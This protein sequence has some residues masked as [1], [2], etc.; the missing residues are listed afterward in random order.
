V[1]IATS[2][3]L[4]SVLGVLGGCI[5]LP[6]L[7]TEAEVAAAV[8]CRPATLQAW[9]TT[10]RVKLPFFRVGRL[11]R[12]SKSDVYAYLESRRHDPQLPAA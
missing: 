6:E 12:Y 11:V 2:M 4:L 5:E 9:R 1:A 10:G 7:M 8:G 3:V